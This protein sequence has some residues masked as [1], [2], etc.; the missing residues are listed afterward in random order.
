MLVAVGWGWYQAGRGLEA[1]KEGLKHKNKAILKRFSHEAG[2]G[3][4]ILGGGA[5]QA[6]FEDARQ[7]A[8]LGVAMSVQL[9]GVSEAAFDGLL[10][11]RVD[12]FAVLHQSVHVDALLAAF[13]HMPH[14]DFNL[15]RALRALL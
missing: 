5:E 1:E 10:S 4:D 8:H 2:D 13:P 3:F 15:V 6:L 11:S 14:H 12:G 7:P 9:F